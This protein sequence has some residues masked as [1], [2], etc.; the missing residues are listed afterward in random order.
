MKDST[1]ELIAVS[2]GE[3]GLALTPQP[4]INTQIKK[5]IDLKFKTQTTVNNIS[6]NIGTDEPAWNNSF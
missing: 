2:G 6:S 4:E 1:Y 3:T 5:R